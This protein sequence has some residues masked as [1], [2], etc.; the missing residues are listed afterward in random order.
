MNDNNYVDWSVNDRPNRVAVSVKEG[1]GW[2]VDR[3]DGKSGSL[4]VC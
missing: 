2:R 4:V 1:D 3:I